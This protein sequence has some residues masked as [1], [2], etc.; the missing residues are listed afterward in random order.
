MFNKLKRKIKCYFK[1][2]NFRVV[3]VFRPGSRRIKCRRCGL[4]MGMNDDVRAYI[5]WTPDLED[6]YIFQGYTVKEPRFQE[7]AS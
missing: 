1:G 4:D 5:P 2:H 6:L 7:T 3:Q